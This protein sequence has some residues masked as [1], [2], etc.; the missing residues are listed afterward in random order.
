MPTTKT[1]AKVATPSIT[2]VLEEFT[3]EKA[4]KVLKDS[5]THNRKVTEGH[6]KALADQMRQGAWLPGT[7]IMFGAK[8]ILL[9]GQHRLR[10]VVASNTS[11]FFVVVRGASL[12]TQLVIDTG[13]KRSLAEQ[14][15]LGGVANPTTTAG[16]LRPYYKYKSGHDAANIFAGSYKKDVIAPTYP[17]LIDL[18][19]TNKEEVTEAVEVGIK[20]ARKIPVGAVLG[21]FMFWALSEIDKD[22]AVDFFQKL[23]DGT[24]LASNDPI[25][26]LRE[27]IRKDKEHSTGINVS[28]YVTFAYTIKAWNA[29]REGRSITRI[30][31]R[32]GGSKSDVFPKPV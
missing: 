8:N 4:S 28:Q 14:L 10:A 24:N 11:Q 18:Y 6:V 31:Y 15:S 13:K 30:H 29:Y 7:S 16:A 21:A 20:L 25:Y 32:P 1:Q 3:P 27:R 17:M 23:Q 5:N 12:A 22:D 19:E 9:D 2:T 26:V